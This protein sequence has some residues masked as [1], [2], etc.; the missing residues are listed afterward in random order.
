MA[1][2]RQCG[3]WKGKLNKINMH[4]L[5]LNVIVIVDMHKII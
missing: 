1:E 5:S 2:T 4:I 3:T